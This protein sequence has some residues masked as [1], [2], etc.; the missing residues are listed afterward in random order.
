MYNVINAY[1]LWVKYNITFKCRLGVFLRCIVIKCLSKKVGTY[2]NR[3][4]VKTN[5][6]RGRRSRM[7]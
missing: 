1:N 6:T 3:L 2:N 4:R 5:G 7:I